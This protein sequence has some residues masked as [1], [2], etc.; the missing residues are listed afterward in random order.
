MKELESQARVVQGALAG[1]DPAPSS[2]PIPP[3]PQ[4]PLI[5]LTA[6]GVALEA[7]RAYN[8][9][10]RM[11]GLQDLTRSGLINQVGDARA[12]GPSDALVLAVTAMRQSARSL[13]P[14]E[15]QP[16]PSLPA[17]APRRSFKNHLHR[18]IHRARRAGGDPNVP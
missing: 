1:A 13:S 15:S 18:P 9:N 17:K 14:P 6:I 8:T 7:S 4:P 16:D 11:V 5:D 2:P 12:Q 3:S 10:L